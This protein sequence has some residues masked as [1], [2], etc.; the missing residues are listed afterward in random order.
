MTDSAESPSPIG[1]IIILGILGLGLGVFFYFDLGGYVSLE[2][3]KANRDD[4]L[5]YT[6][7]N[8]A[9]AVVLYVAIY[10]LQ[11][12]FSLPGGHS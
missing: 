11:T 4:L 6:N 10:I 12:A 2:A 8:F 7:A 3:L 5:A 1:K 9:A